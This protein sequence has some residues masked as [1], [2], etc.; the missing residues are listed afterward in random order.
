MLVSGP[1]D[2]YAF[3]AVT[4]LGKWSDPIVDTKFSTQGGCWV[5]KLVEKEADR[6]LSDE[7]RQY[8][9]DKAYSDWLTDVHLQ[10]NPE[11]DISGLSD[12][13]T[14]AIDRAKKEL[15]Y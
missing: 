9:I 2:G 6:L 10:Y 3:G 14:W 1:F 15:G 12:V 4:E 8:L 5:V 7:D 11:I 13:L